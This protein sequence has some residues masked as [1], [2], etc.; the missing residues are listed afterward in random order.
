MFYQFSEVIK[1]SRALQIVNMSYALKCIMSL[2]N[3]VD[4]FKYIKV[5]N[6][7]Y[8]LEK[9]WKVAMRAAYTQF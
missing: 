1:V 8:N 9:H 7:D 2:S 3:V 4:T 6:L 5:Y